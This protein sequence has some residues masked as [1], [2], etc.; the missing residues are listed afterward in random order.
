MSDMTAMDLD[1]DATAR[2]PRSLRER[3]QPPPDRSHCQLLA[4]KPL[5][6]K[7]VAAF[8]LMELHRL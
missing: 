7:L 3:L 2:T 5:Q 6:R 8:S 4:P 1:D